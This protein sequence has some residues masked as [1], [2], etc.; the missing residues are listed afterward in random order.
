LNKAVWTDLALH[1]DPRLSEQY[2]TSS[3]ITLMNVRRVL[4]SILVVFAFQFVFQVCGAG[5]SATAPRTETARCTMSADDQSWIEKALGNWRVAEQTELD[6]A[7]SALPTVVVID[8]ACSYVA[9]PR[10]DGKL[11]WKGTHHSGTIT[12]PDGKTAP[13]G[14]ISFAAPD[15]GKATTGFFAMSLPSVWRAKGIQSGLGLERLMDGV[16]LHEMTHTRQFYFVNPTMDRLTKQYGLSDDVGDD[17]LQDAYEKN[18]GYV[19]D[20]EAERDLLYAAALAPTD[21]EAKAMTR[22][23]LG[24]IRARRAKWFVGDSQKWT[25]IDDIFLTMEG[26]GQW[27]AYAWFTDK[28]GL[29]LDPAKVLPEVRRKRNRWTQDEGLAVFLVVNRLVPG[30]QKFA[31]APKPE[32]A[33]A[34]LERASN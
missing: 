31:F 10:V 33:E 7:P 29:D 20:Y 9:A 34:L 8:A 17:S 27:T 21:A 11:V 28:Q 19:A 25:P 13:F 5:Q 23:A 22:Q 6:L 24:K 32:L 4:A 12:L 15:E 3:R 16:L 26:L 2:E 14:V 30:W 1:F 18:A